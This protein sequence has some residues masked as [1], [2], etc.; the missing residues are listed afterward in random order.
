MSN[1]SLY[2]IYIYI[3][4][5][6]YESIGF[7]RV[8]TIVRFQFTTGYS[9]YGAIIFFHVSYTE[10]SRN[11]STSFYPPFFPL[12][13]FPLSLSLSLS[14]LKTSRWS[15]IDRRRLDSLDRTIEQS[16]R[17]KKLR[18]NTRERYP[19]AI[20]DKYACCKKRGGRFRDFERRHSGTV[21]EKQLSCW[22]T[23]FPEDRSSIHLWLTYVFLVE[24]ILHAVGQKL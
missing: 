16:P 17:S 23:S 24:R 18:E 8:G 9:S 13:T 7:Q 4:I 11:L 6:I 1:Y 10:C 14:N 5:Y 21:L 19:P 3:Y 12:H 15:D 22:V 2:S 20:L